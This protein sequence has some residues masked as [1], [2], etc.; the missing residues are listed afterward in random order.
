MSVHQEKI[1]FEYEF[2]TQVSNQ[3]YIFDFLF[4]FVASLYFVDSL[5]VVNGLF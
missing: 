4:A 3:I 1:R 2:T 5:N